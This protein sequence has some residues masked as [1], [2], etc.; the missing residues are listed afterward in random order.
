[1]VSAT[2]GFNK[3]IIFRA[4]D[5]L[6]QLKKNHELSSTSA[7]VVNCILQDY[8]L[9]Y[10]VINQPNY[11][12]QSVILNNRLWKRLFF[13]ATYSSELVY[14]EI[15]QITNQLLELDLNNPESLA[16]K[17]LFDA[18]LREKVLEKL[19][20]VKGCWQRNS[21]LQNCSENYSNKIGCGT[22]FFWGI[23]RDGRHFP[24]CL[25]TNPST[26]ELL[27]GIDNKGNKWGFSYN[28]ESLIENIKKQNISPSLFTC[29][30]LI[31]F[32]RGI[33]C[34]GGYYQAVYLPT[35]QQ[36]LASAL[37]ASRSYSDISPFI[38]QIPTDY[39]LS[40]MQAV[41][42]MIGNNFLVP[43]GP[44]EII[45]R[46]GLP[47]SDLN[48]ILSI[49]V[50]EAHL[51]SLIETLPDIAPQEVKDKEWKKFYAFNCNAFLK[52]KLVTLC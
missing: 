33:I 45:A 50:K 40:G 3:D 43:A 4:L 9:R 51:A 22:T 19:D 37:R 38:E 11:S 44:L 10:E 1:M 48:K 14:L 12:S 2:P 7:S 34:I 26:G 39:Y 13:P 8:Y 52:H 31:C 20:G 28:P 49:P 16:Y 5:K 21:L 35:I 46:G 27:F 29:F 25:G 24:L 30:L 23:D 32:A 42:G 6:D 18:D 15:E 17:V 47:D 36:G 41:M